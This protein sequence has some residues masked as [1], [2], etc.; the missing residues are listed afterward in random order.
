MFL[1]IVC[2]H[3]TPMLISVFQAC[4]QLVWEVL[5]IQQVLLSSLLGCGLR[6]SYPESWEEFHIE[7]YLY[8]ELYSADLGFYS[9]FSLL[10]ACEVSTVFIIVESTWKWSENKYP[11]S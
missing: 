10:P 5:L 11:E 1:F 6:S 7:S 4:Y 2:V 8:L 9:I 3:T